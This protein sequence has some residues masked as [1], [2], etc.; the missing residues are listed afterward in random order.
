[1]TTPKTNMANKSYKPY[2]AYESH[3]PYA[4]LL[5]LVVLTFSSCLKDQE[6]Y[7]DQPASE[8]LKTT[9]SDVTRILR[10]AEYGWEFEYYPSSTLDYGGIVYTVRFDSLT[11]TV[12]CSLVPGTTETSFYRLTNDNGP[13]LTFD[14]YNSLMHYFSTPN[15]DEYEAK[16]G[17]FEF[18]VSDISDD[19]ITLYG[20]KTHNTMY[21]RRLSASPDNYA[22]S[23]ISVFD[24]FVSGFQGTVDDI[25][26]VG[27]FNL[28]DKSIE[29]ASQGD[30]ITAHFAYN[31]KGIRLYAPFRIG[32]TAMQT[33]AFDIENQT[34]TCLDAGAEGVVLQGIPLSSD[35]APYHDYE[36]TYV[37]RY[38]G[39]SSVRV[40]LVPN[41]LDG[42]Y[43]LQGLSEHYELVLNYDHTTGYLTL[44]P[45]VIATYNG[46]TV[47]F[48]TYNSVSGSVWLTEEASFTLKWNNNKIYPAYNFT[49]TSSRY[50]CN[51]GIFGML[52]LNEEGTAY[53]L[54]VLAEPD[55]IVGGSALLSNLVSLQ[56]LRN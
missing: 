23:T 42:T 41:R 8:R 55:W 30:T 51:S 3:K 45:Q 28:G 27:T 21:L 24:N 11:A 26:V 44:A 13:V 33:F 15:S 29:I 12:G 18:I 39:N 17:E 5:L 38:N 2:K 31:D 25:E 6:D 46:N 34:F 10:S 56:K 36:A 37:L 20:K 43:R 32:D 7:F 22:Q 35:I 54:E 16:G 47:Y 49:P 50:D 4:L 52:V 19:Q 14:T 48:L 9:I 1:M 40:S 53:S